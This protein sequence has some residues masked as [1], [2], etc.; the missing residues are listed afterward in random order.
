MVREYVDRVRNSVQS[1]EEFK[2][3]L[4]GTS[5]EKLRESYTR[6]A[7][8]RVKRNL[9]ISKVIEA[10]K[11][12]VSDADVDAQIAVFTAN[13]GDKQQEETARL[14]TPENRDSLRWWIKTGKARKLLVDKARAD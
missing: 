7:E 9:V 14:N 8:Q 3:V 5:E 1:E 6:Q 4:S 13:A 2:S 12:E 10:E 11:F